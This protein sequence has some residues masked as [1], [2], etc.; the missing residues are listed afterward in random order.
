MIHERNARNS[1]VH[2]VLF[3]RDRPARDAGAKD[4][5]L[6]LPQGQPLF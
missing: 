3:V 2:S 4:K 1:A 5:G 6:S